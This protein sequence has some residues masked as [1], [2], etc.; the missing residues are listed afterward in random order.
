MEGLNGKVVVFAGAGGIANATADQKGNINKKLCKQIG[1]A[2]VTSK[3]AG[4][5]DLENLELFAGKFHP[6]I[7]K[8]P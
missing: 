2:T 3:N 8:R 7:P 4:N 1:F 5:R 6:L